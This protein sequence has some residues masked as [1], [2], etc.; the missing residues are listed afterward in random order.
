[1]CICLQ[2]SEFIGIMEMWLDD[3]YNWSLYYSLLLRALAGTKC[4]EN[5]AVQSVNAFLTGQITD[6]YLLVENRDLFP[7]SPVE[8]D[9]RSQKDFHNLQL[10]Y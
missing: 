1:M 10:Y 3:S 4:I 8:A 2:G 6:Q 9:D 7:L 5:D